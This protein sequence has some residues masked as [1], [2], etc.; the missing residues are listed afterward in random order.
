MQRELLEKTLSR[1]RQLHGE[2]AAFTGL[3]VHQ[4]GSFMQFH[5][6]PDYGK[7]SLKWTGK[8]ITI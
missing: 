6:V 1:R 3:A 2:G 4:D 8:V 7:P 5:Q